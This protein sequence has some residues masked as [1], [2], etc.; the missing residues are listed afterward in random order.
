MLSHKPLGNL[1]DI[2]GVFWVST[3]AAFQS[4]SINLL[5]NK[6][7]QRGR[8]AA[9][10][11]QVLLKFTGF[12]RCLGCNISEMCS[13]SLT[14]SS[15]II[16]W[17]CKDFLRHECQK[18]YHNHRNLQI[19]KTLIKK[20]RP[21]YNRPFLPG[22]YYYWLFHFESEGQILSTGW[23][24]HLQEDAD[25]LWKNV[26]ELFKSCRGWMDGD[27]INGKQMFSLTW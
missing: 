1:P 5:K 10:V 7:L 15:W 19:C 25:T 3:D 27:C 6:N 9:S 4:W 21:Y 20:C 22:S 26:C 14:S 12:S 11:L 24:F 8:I 17:S 16:L 18:S 13:S 2:H 23:M